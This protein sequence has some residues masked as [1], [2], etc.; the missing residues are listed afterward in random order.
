MYQDFACNS[1]QI[2]TDVPKWTL[3][4]LLNH[5]IEPD[6][7]FDEMK[8]L[9]QEELKCL[10]GGARRRVRRVGVALRRRRSSN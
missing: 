3:A 6:L 7:N 9:E 1:N 10:K 2:G 8:K 5:K 4:R